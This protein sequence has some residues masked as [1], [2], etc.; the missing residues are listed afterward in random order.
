MSL[1]YTSY[2]AQLSNLMVIPSSDP[3][4]QTFL[5]GCISYAENRCY[6]ELD[7]LATSVT[8]VGQL[9]SGNRSFSLPT[10]IGTYL[11]VEDFN[12]LTPVTALSSNGQ[13]NPLVFTTPAGVDFLYPGAAVTT[14]V[15]QYVAMV[16][17]SSVIVGPAPDKAYTVEVRGTQRPT[18]LS[19]SNSST[20][21]TSMLPDLFIAASMVFG[22]GY[23]RD[24]GSQAD[25]PQMGASWEAQYK[26]LFQSADVEEFRK[27]YQSQAWTSQTPSPI[28][29]PPRV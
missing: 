11:V 18:P 26:Q 24:F 1:D 23:M 28:A 2:V 13:R 10:N 5:P 14:G 9:S 16:N 19:A 6:R 20:I 4:F 17:S 8:D 21:L 25:N 12:V 15:P 22:S 29:T 3:N 27:V 7:L